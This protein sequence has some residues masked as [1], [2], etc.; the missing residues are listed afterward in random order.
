MVTDDP[1]Y[2]R[3]RYIR[4]ADDWIVGVTGPKD[5]AE[6]IKDAIQQFLKDRLKLELSQEKTTIVHAKTEEAN[7]L[8]TRLTIGR[9]SSSESKIVTCRPSSK[10]PYRKRA[11]G[12][13]PI[14]K[15]PIRTLVGK[16]HQKGFCDG[17]GY[18]SSKVDWVAFDVEQIINLFKSINTG[19]LNYYRFVNNFAAMSRIQYILRFSLAKTLAHKLRISMA[20]VFREHG[21]TLRFQWET[22]EGTRTVEFVP[23]TDWTV[24]LDGFM[25]GTDPPDPLAKYIQFKAKSRLRNPCFIC[26]SKDKVQ[27]HHVR[28]IR[29]M[30]NKKPTG[31]TA[32]M[33]AFNRKQMP[34]CEE[35]HQKIHRGEY[36]GISLKDLLSG[37]RA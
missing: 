9:P 15:A 31:F 33:R 18:P 28:H 24:T 30:G 29:K 26:G 22:R 20:K 3:V 4:Y 10:R 17:D 13:N 35:C 37:D 16:L 21:K 7:F 5:L 25:I 2:V 32:L 23:N 6:T 34:V 11:T 8:G 1:D 36:D 12:W 27:M 19:L 14:L